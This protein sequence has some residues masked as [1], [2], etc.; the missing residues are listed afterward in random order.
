M[1]Y[2]LLKYTVLGQEKSPLPPTAFWTMW[3]VFCSF[4][5]EG[6]GGR[7][8]STGMCGTKDVLMKKWWIRNLNKFVFNLLVANADSIFLCSYILREVTISWIQG[9]YVKKKCIKSNNSS[10]SDR[11]GGEAISSLSFTF[12]QVPSGVFVGTLCGW[13]EPLHNTPTQSQRCWVAPCG[14]AFLELPQCR[15]R[16]EERVGIAGGGE[17][18]H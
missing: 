13:F 5:R 16:G 18:S 6:W 12:L 9:L 15:A 14:F 3:R 17:R 4:V 2:I 10:P 8:I 1:Y 7:I 11:V